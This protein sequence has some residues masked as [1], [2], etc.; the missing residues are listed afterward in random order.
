MKNFC[1]KYS[2]D[3][4]YPFFSSESD[5]SR[6]LFPFCPKVE[7]FGKVSFGQDIQFIISSFE[8]GENLGDFGIARIFE[9]EKSLSKSLKAMSKVKT[10][11]PF[12]TYINDFLSSYTKEFIPSYELEHLSKFHNINQIDFILNELKKQIIEI[13]NLLRTF[14]ENLCFCHG[15]LK[16]SNILIHNDMFKFTDLHRGFLGSQFFDITYLLTYIGL[17][18]DQ[19]KEFISNIY[20]N[21]GRNFNLKDFLEYETNYDLCLRIHAYKNLLQS[22]VEI[23][24]SEERQ[25]RKVWDS[26]NFFTINEKFLRQDPILEKTSALFQKL[27]YQN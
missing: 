10:E 4:S 23:F 14:N 11:R 12:R 1:F 2:L 15:S 7:K 20:K 13:S 25:L 19:Q 24:S 26:L 16:P 3:T 17:S 6:Q 8:E 9:F 18:K 21:Q 22:L 5:A 27:V